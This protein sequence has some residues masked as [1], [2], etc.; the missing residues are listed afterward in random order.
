MLQFTLIRK[1]KKDTYTIGE[2]YV[3]GK[4]TCN[5]CEDADRKLNAFMSEAQVKKAKIKGQTAIPT[6]SYEMTV[7]MSP[8]FGRRLIEVKGVKGFS[9][10]RIHRGNTAADSEGCILPGENKIKG[11]VINSTRDEELLT[12]MVENAVRCNEQCLLTII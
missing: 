5:T 8:K 3:N 6:G 9:G 4:L 1:Y 2:L 12:Q 7:S 11:G 10:I